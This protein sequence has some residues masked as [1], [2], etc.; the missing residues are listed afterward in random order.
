MTETQPAIC[1]ESFQQ[2]WFIILSQCQVHLDISE[3]PNVSAE[4][5]YHSYEIESHSYNF[6]YE[7]K[8]EDNIEHTVIVG[9]KSHFFL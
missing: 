5:T 8:M 6:S 9:Y 2:L 4:P 7:C 3:I 1:K